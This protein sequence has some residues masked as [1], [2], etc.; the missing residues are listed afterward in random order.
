MPDTLTPSQRSYCMSRVKGKD[1]S[2]E[3]IV[4]KELSRA[5]IRF[6]KHVKHLP[7][8]PDIVFARMKLAVF[9]DGDF[10]HGYRFPSWEHK[11]SPFWRKK[12]VLNRARDIRNFAKLR[13]MGW[14]VMRVWGH[15]VNGDLEGVVRKIRNKLAEE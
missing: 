12:I 8:K 11:L 6:R 5:G 9:I 15:E 10:W 4:R 2:L 3:L 14:T 13:R 1:T 7:G